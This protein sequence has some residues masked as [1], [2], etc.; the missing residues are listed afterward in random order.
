MTAGVRLC[1]HL[2]NP[3]GLR[4]EA[5][6][7]AGI[8]WPCTEKFPYPETLPGH[9]WCGG[10]DSLIAR[11]SVV[12][13]SVIPN[14]YHMILVGTHRIRARDRN[15]T[16]DLLDGDQALCLLSYTDVAAGH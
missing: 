5:L 11:E 15:R 8:D 1:L 2:R 7:P 16:C 13:E 9:D 3:S 12:T 6:Y 10:A 14:P 4:I